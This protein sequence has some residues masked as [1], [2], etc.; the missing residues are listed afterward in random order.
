MKGSD[1][2]TELTL[3]GCIECTSDC[4]DDADCC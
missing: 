2:M 1:V 4:C 3:C